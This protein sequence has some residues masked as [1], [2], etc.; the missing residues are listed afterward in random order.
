MEILKEKHFI[1][2]DQLEFV[3]YY[4]LLSQPGT[5][6]AHVPG[7]GAPA[8]GTDGEATARG[9]GRGIESAL[10]DSEGSQD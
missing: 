9:D 8:P 2:E 3:I 10:E 6:L 7:N 4:F 5:G 1:F